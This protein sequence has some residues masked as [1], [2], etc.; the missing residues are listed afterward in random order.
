MATDFPGF[1]ADA[2][3]EVD[4]SNCWLFVIL[5]FYCTLLALLAASNA[6]Y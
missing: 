2:W 3:F 4:C 5:I 6:Y 1:S